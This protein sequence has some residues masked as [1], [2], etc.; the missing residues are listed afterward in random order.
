[1]ARLGGWDG[2]R[3]KRQG[4]SPDQRCPYYECDDVPACLSFTVYDDGVWEGWLVTSGC[5]TPKGSADPFHTGL[6]W[7]VAFFAVAIQDSAEDT[8]QKRSQVEGE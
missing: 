2:D 8:G 7:V 4:T 6:P 5:S 1:M 3:V